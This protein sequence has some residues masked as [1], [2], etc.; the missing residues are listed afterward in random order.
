M[1]NDF[2][3]ETEIEA[4][5][6]WVA[7][8]LKLE[9]NKALVDIPRDYLSDKFN[10]YGLEKFMKNLENSFKAIN[11]MVPARLQ[12][13]E[14]RLYILIHQRY[15]LTPQ[16]L[17]KMFEKVGKKAYGICM[18]MGCEEIPLIP[19]RVSLTPKISPMKVYC[20]NC[21]NVYEPNV[22][23]NL[24]GCAFGRYFAH[25]FELTYKKRLIKSKFR[26]YEPRIHGFKIHYT[27]ES[28]EEN[29]F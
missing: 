6:R 28:D 13:D 10:Y 27:S 21:K 9:G 20:Y 16:G 5:S 4:D 22:S 29:N 1:S 7:S 12:S 14:S 25:I 11:S 3:S 26:Q 18:R 19:F 8:Y 23:T 17:E 15:I 2:S 24:D